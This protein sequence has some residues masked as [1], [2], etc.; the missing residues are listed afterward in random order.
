MRVLLVDPPWIVE[1][2]G[3]LWKNVRSCLPSLGLATIAACLELD[4]HDVSILDCTAEALSVEGTKQRMAGVSPPPDCVGISATCATFDASLLLAAR[5]RELFPSARIVMGGV[6]PTVA[7]ESALS[8]PAVDV[9][10]LGEG[11]RTMAEIVGGA[12][13]DAI[14]GIAY[15][16]NGEILRTPPREPIP[17]LDSLPLPAYHLLPMEKYRP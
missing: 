11:E 12:S 16:H 6:H 14:A 2:E 13:F 8:C 10:V 15:R 4:G 5:A 9:V 17:D 1:R 7:P 3:N